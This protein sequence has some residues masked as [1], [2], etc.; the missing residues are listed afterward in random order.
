[1]GRRIVIDQVRARTARPSEVSDVRLAE[2]P[3]A[4]DSYERLLVAR[5]LRAAIAGLPERLR[6]VIIDVYVRER[7][8]AETAMHLDIPEGTVKSRTYHALRAL[9]QLLEERGFQMP[10]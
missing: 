7:S 3:A 5:E 1:V 9:R 10:P 6:R 2:R 8:V 4:E